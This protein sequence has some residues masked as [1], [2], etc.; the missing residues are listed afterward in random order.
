[1]SDAFSRQDIQGTL[2]EQIRSCEIFLKTQLQK[3]VMLTGSMERTEILEYPLE[4]ARELVINAVAHRDYTLH[5]DNI[6]IY[7]FSNR[8]EVHSPGKLP[9]PMTVANLRDE[10]FSRNPAIVQVLSDMNY[11]EKLGYG[12]DRVIELMQTRSQRPP[13]FIERDGG[14][15]VILYRESVVEHTQAPNVTPVREPVKPDFRGIYNGQEINPR[16]ETAIAFL[17]NSGKHRVTNGELKDLLPDVHP[18]TL[19]RDLSDLVSKE[20]LVKMGQK[21]G[22]YYVLKDRT[23]R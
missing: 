9:G 12:L 11:I 20:I 10:R 7:L 22:S 14:F 6:H 1:M 3:E 15:H 8:M 5:G 19:R 2:P 21:R 4:A 16:Q 23:E 17:L 18:E 13:D